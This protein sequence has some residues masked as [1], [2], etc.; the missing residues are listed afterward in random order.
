[1]YSQKSSFPPLLRLTYLLQQKSDAAL[2]GKVGIS[3]S[4]AHMLSGLSGSVPVSQHQLAVMLG[5]TESNISRQLGLMKK[6]GLV[7]ITKN[8]NDSRAR[9]VKLTAKGASKYKAAQAVLKKQLAQL[10]KLDSAKDRKI[11]EQVV[12]N[13]LSALAHDVA[14]KRRLVR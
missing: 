1:M 11:S 13:L 3:L 7:S 6:Q 4:H 14:T 8:K 10:Q 5:Q 9:D 2:M 12:N